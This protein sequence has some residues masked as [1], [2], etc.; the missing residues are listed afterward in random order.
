MELPGH[1]P[2][3]CPGAVHA[4]SA[5]FSF[6]NP[7]VWCFVEGIR[8]T[9]T[10][11]ATSYIGIHTTGEIHFRPTQDH[12][13]NNIRVDVEMQ[14]TESELIKMVKWSTDEEALLFNSPRRIQKD[15]AL[16]VNPCLYI[17]T[18]V[19]VAPGTTLEHLVVDSESLSV[20]FHEGLSF[21]ADR[22]EI[23][24]LPGHVSMPDHDASHTAIEY[25]EI[26][27]VVD[28][29]SVSGSY[30]LYD[31]L[32]VKVRS[33]SIN[34][35]IK[36][37][38]AAEGSPKPAT[39]KLNGISGSIRVKVLESSVST[40]RNDDLRRPIVP[41]R[42]YQ[43]WI[44][45]TS[46]STDVDLIHG[47]YTQ[48]H[49]QSG[50]IRAILTP[51]GDPRI[52]TYTEAKSLSGEINLQV[53]SSISYPGVP[54]RSFNGN[55]EART[56]SLKIE[57]PSEWQGRMEGSVMSGSVK[58][59]WAGLKIIRDSRVGYVWRVIKGV[60]GEGESTF[61]FRSA[62]G[63]VDLRSGDGRI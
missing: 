57:Y 34:I 28:S 19:W 40:E 2:K 24:T 63:S 1:A 13:E 18:T 14:S 51:Y 39:L 61:S 37:E 46:G 15:S 17:S 22:V 55:Y 43:T 33:G 7:G 50:S 3:V 35:D 10:T 31:L 47:S 52:S 49:S 44:T 6:R 16:S 20:T 9:S 62:S 59:I 54:L 27:I 29:G 26:D 12:L 8:D 38:E 42:D 23:L 58:I 30:S 56:G 41:N 32:S 45:S 5:S 60:K 21:S 25:R 53:R 36:L 4:G 48:L 11:P